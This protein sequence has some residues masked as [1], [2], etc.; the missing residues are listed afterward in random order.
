MYLCFSKTSASAP[1][2]SF[3]I[4][5]HN[6]ACSGVSCSCDLLTRTKT[7][8][9]LG[10]HIDENLNFKTHIEV[11][12]ARIRKIINVMRNLRYAACFETLKLVY[13]ALCQSII[14][15]CIPC[16]GCAA[17]TFIIQAERAQ[18]SVLKVMLRKPYRYSTTNLYA[19]AGV[20][21]V[22]Q[23]YILKTSLLVHKSVLSCPEY[24]SLLNRRIFKLKTP[25]V[26]SKFAQR[27]GCFMK[28]HIYNK[29]VQSCDI[30]E[31]SLYEAKNLLIK[32]LS[33]L[34]YDKTEEL[35]T[36]F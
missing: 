7:M 32:W 35:L 17:K 33:S 8:K 26:K 20:P 2:N 1:D 36:I 24:E 23:L 13:Y 19:E 10:L 6:D 15:Y 11:L 29:V 27:L 16:W 18:R 21:T 4:A 30:K 3:K 25:S 31:K 9:Y 14:V 28:T 12:S 22:R 5:S 34:N